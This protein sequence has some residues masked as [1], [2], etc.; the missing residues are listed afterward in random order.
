[1][2]PGERMGEL[3][4]P[5]VVAPTPTPGTPAPAKPAGVGELEMALVSNEANRFF[6][7]NAM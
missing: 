2:L 5:P 6:Y 3:G 7:I 4:T 1:M